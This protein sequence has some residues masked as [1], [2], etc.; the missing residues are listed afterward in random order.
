M[1]CSRRAL[2]Y[3]V[4]ILDK[5]PGYDDAFKQMK[6]RKSRNIWFQKTMSLSIDQIKVIVNEVLEERDWSLSDHR[7]EH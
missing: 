2:T 4:E 3:E 5:E 7:T 6:S 1:N